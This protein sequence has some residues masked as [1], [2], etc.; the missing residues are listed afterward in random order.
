MAVTTYNVL[1]AKTDVNGVWRKVQTP[2]QIAAQY[3]VEEW[4]MITGA[5]ID[6][7]DVDWSARSIEVPLDLDDDINIASIP[8]GGFEARPSS[9]NP[10]DGTL[11]WI[12]LNGRFTVSKTAKWIDQRNRRA[13][14]E[15]Q[16]MYQ[17]RKKLEALA[18]RVGVYFYGFSTGTIALVNGAPAADVFT[19]DSLYGSAGLNTR[20]TD[21]FTVGDF[22]GVLNPTGPAL[23]GVVK[24]TAI[25]AATPSI[26]LASTPAGSAD[27][28]LIVFANS[29]EDALIAQTDR[30]NALVGLLD[31][32]TSTSV[33]NVSSA[34]KPKWDV[35]Y[36]DTAGG[37][38]SGIKLR[39][40]KQGIQNKGSGQMNQVFWDQGVE[41]DVVAQLQ[42]GVRFANPFN[43]EMDGSPKAK[44]VS[45]FGSRF[46][47]AGFVF[48]MDMK[49]FRKLVLLPKPG[50]PAWD[51]GDKLVDQSGFIFPI[52]YPCALITLNRGNFAYFSG[53]TTQ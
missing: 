13:M 26:T 30:D 7:F 19:L 24:I 47:P 22:V 5:K 12:L 2:L 15:R 29:V 10:V 46:T 51:D 25:T 38:F 42:A 36:S 40:A 41:N 9:P 20:V 14:I 18:R 21:P 52:D 16:L 34:T 39:K 37:R 35:G 6:E 32:S 4:D 1:T 44:G 11:T 49:S 53:L 43:M 8:E 31:I 50:T 48:A 27:N 23:R 28:D 45:L 17:G 33:H 3:M